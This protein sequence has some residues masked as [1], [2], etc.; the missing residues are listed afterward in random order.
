M[1]EEA[2]RA[3]VAMCHPVVA[4]MFHPAE[5]EPYRPEEAEF[6]E[7]EPCRREEEAFREAA[8]C[9][10]VVSPEVAFRQA[11]CPVPAASPH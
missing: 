4:V 5:E 11:V 9:H 3:A 8:A 2:D 1:W 7:A 6:P 10:R